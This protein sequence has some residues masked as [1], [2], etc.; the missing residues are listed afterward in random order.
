MKKKSLNSLS[1]SQPDTITPRT[2]AQGMVEFA[3]VLPIL[4]L[5]VFG[6]I[7]FGRLLFMFASVSSASREGARYGAAAGYFGGVQRFED[8]TGIEDAAIRIGRFAGVGSS[9][10]AIQYTKYNDD[11]STST[12]TTCPPP[13]GQINLADRIVVRVTRNYQPLVPLVNIPPIPISSTTARTIVKSVFIAGTPGPTSTDYPWPGGNTPTASPTNTPTDT[14]TA[15]PTDI[16]TPT[17]TPTATDTPTPSDTPT[18]TSTPTYGPS[19]TPTDTETPTITPSE[20]PTPT[21]TPI[22]AC[23]PAK[24]S[25]VSGLQPDIY[26]SKAFYSVYFRIRN[27][28]AT[29]LIITGITFDW[30]P[31]DGGQGSELPLDEIRFDNDTDWKKTCGI[32]TNCIWNGWTGTES[33]THIDIC[34]SGCSENFGGVQ[35][36]RTLFVTEEKDLK[37]VFSD[38]LKSSYN[39]A[40]VPNPFPYKVRVVFDNSCYIETLQTQYIRP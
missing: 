10:V 24:Y 7:E 18:A 38:E 39:A 32:S 21:A 8:C 5:L 9:D 22:P 31:P 15:T 29:P 37:F 20:T 28:S 19:L 35:A 33:F 40:Y 23:D 25:I 3:L 1:K 17:D 4:L 30:P 27:I 34:T 13:A 16:F 36:Y 2:K 26:E 12:I 6:I 11:G 14:P